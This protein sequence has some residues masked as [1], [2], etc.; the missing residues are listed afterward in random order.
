MTRV[1]KR[2]AAGSVV[3]LGAGGARL[4]EPEELLEEARR[5][6]AE[7]RRAA[8]LDAE[9]I[10][11]EA[12]KDGRER[13]VQAVTELL[14]AARAIAERA[15]REA[16]EDLRRLAVH[17]AGKLLG[18]ALALDPG[19]VV[20]VTAQALGQAGPGRELVVRAH[21]D[22]VDALE[23]GRPRLIERAHGQ[24]RVSLRPDPA[25]GRGGCVIESELGI[26][27]ARLSTQ[28]EAIER[29]LKSLAGAGGSS[30]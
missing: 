20:D 27:D 14:V 26:V 7:L 19:L 10:R 17:I 22:D 30:A 18:R 5:E 15:R 21:P 16:A 6:A 13:G 3:T 1:I 2:A 4:A 12:A 24:A 11:A 29:A 9:R 8:E 25:V 23:R 28:L